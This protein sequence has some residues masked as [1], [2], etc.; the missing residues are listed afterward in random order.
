VID[1]LWYRHQ[2]RMRLLWLIIGLENLALIIV[3][4]V[5]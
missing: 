4:V 2:R 5:R 1:D 3:K